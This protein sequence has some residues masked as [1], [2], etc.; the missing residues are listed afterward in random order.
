LATGIQIGI[1]RGGII[2]K[3]KMSQVFSSSIFI[4]YSQSQVDAN[5]GQ[6]IWNLNY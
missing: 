4:G 1:Y 2:D 3:D 5:M 6:A